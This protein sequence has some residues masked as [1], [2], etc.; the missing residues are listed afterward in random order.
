M[1]TSYVKQGMSRPGSVM[2]YK[3]KRVVQAKLFF[4]KQ[5]Q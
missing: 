4:V 1:A 5:L 2:M 3:G